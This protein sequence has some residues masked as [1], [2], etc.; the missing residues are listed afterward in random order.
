MR[1]SLFPHPDLAGEQADPGCPLF[2]LGL[3][4]GPG[5]KQWWG[6]VGKNGW[7]RKDGEE[8]GEWQGMGGVWGTVKGL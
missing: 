5:A 4:A 8:W 2:S 1:K 7:Q 3:T 6:M